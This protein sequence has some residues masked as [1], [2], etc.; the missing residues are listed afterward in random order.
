VRG[1]ARS[2][3]DYYELTNEIEIERDVVRGAA[4][5]VR[6]CQNCDEGLV[7]HIEERDGY[8]YAFAERCSCFNNWQYGMM[9]LNQLGKQYFKQQGQD[10][11]Y[12]VSQEM[13]DLHTIKEG[14]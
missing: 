13:R 3:E 10:Y 11:K 8:P 7:S 14:V 12:L 6:H 1:Q 2:E 9:K 4:R 5:D